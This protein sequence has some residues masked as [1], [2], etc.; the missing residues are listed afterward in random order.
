MN[1]LEIGYDIHISLNFSFKFG[2]IILIL[3]YIKPTLNYT[4]SYTLLILII[5]I[6][7]LIIK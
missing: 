5:I 2:G 1:I 4:L 7:Y 3:L 6:N